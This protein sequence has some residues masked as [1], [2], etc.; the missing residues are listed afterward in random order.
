[1][2]ARPQDG[3]DTSWPRRKTEEQRKQTERERKRRR[4][5]R[6]KAD[7]VEYAKLN[8]S[9]REYWARYMADLK[10][11]PVAYSAYL[12]KKRESQIRWYHKVIKVDPERLRRHRKASCGRKKLCRLEI[13]VMKIIQIEGVGKIKVYNAV[14]HFLGGGW[15]TIGEETKELAWRLRYGKPTKADLI[16]AS[17]AV[18]AYVSLLERGNARGFE[19]FRKALLAVEDEACKNVLA[20]GE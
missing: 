10:T 15:P 11:D 20:D 3:R 7:P 2:T 14:A 12:A 9:R 5:E 13:V 4:V 6:I 1:M 16:A 8:A 19:T 17:K 18:S